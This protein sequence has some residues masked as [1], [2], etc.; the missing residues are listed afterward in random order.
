MSIRRTLLALAATA[1][2]LMAVPALAAAN[3][4]VNVPEAGETFT[5]S[6]PTEGHLYADEASNVN[7]ESATG[8]G[9]FDKGGATGS[10]KFIFHG[11]TEEELG[12]ACTNEG[13]PE[14]TIETTTLPFDLKTVNGEPA[15]LVTPNTSSGSNHFATFHCVFGF[16]HVAVRGNGV[17]GTITKPG[18]NEKSPTFTV[19]FNATGA[20]AQEHTKV[21]GDGTTYG[22]KAELNTDGVLHAA[23]EDAEG[24]GTFTGTNKY[25]LTK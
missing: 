11:C 25:E 17:I 19:D 14:G 12:T 1:L 22:L 20:T 23:A 7:C 18:Y 15:V 5:V 13:G 8:S 10:I 24:T 6:G 4:M 16:V 2:A 3:P 21:E 9:K